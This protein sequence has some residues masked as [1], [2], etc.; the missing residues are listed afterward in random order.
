MIKKI[1][2]G[3]L[4]TPIYILAFLG[5]WNILILGINATAKSPESLIKERMKYVRP[6]M[7]LYGNRYCSSSS[8]RYG[9][10]VYSITNR[11]CCE[12]SIGL[13]DNE[14]RLGNS[15]ETILYMD[16]K[17]DICVLTSSQKD[18]P[19][20]VAV[21]EFELMDQLLVMGYPSGHVLTPRSGYML[22]LDTPVPVNYGQGLI[23]YRSN[24]SSALIFGG[25]SGSP[26]FNKNGELTNLIYAGP[27]PIFHIAI[28]VPLIDIV[29]VLNQVI[30]GHR[31]LSPNLKYDYPSNFKT[32]YKVLP[33]GVDLVE[34]YVYL[35]CLD[36][37]E[38]ALTIEVSKLDNGYKCS[39]STP[40]GVLIRVRGY[41]AN[42]DYT[43]TRECL[44]YIESIEG[45]LVCVL[46]D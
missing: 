9:K 16:D 20:T 25:N 3:L 46:E 33:K 5:M 12:G 17:H 1:F 19:I 40:N 21:Q 45:T 26:V 27:D 36:K 29:R 6:L 4:K 8:V 30:V 18:T 10:D 14:R 32:N 39:V 28:Q 37:S 38:K 13:G 22:D 23:T 41:G 7:D 2:K 15:I 24:V 43:G 31:Q 44:Y 35:D 42:G 11:H 34:A